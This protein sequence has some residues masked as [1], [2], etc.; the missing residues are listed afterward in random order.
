MARIHIVADF[1]VFQSVTHKG[2]SYS[3]V[4]EAREAYNICI[5]LKV[6]GEL[7]II[8]PKLI[9]DKIRD[10]LNSM[11]KPHFFSM[12]ERDNSAS[13]EAGYDYQ[14]CIQETA[15]SN[16][17]KARTIILALEEVKDK[18][19]I[20]DN[21]KIVICSPAEFITN[22]KR[23]SELQKIMNIQDF[24]FINYLIIVFFKSKMVDGLGNC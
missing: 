3:G 9:E 14:S 1:R 7:E 20:K 19:K 15:K 2:V 23:A 11:Q 6:D 13:S 12:V 21:K 24:P 16:S 17:F 5:N 8:L 18:E 10:N 4:L 22:F